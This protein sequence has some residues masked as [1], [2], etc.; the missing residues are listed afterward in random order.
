VAAELK[1]AVKVEARL[2][3]G[4]KGIFDV[5]VDG[6]LVYSKY[7]THKFPDQGEVAKLLGRA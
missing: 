4:S 7:Q 5:K 1:D 3:E 6:K 2:I